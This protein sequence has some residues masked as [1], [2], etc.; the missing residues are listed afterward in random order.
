M[1]K[2]LPPQSTVAL[3]MVAPFSQT[4]LRPPEL[5]LE[6]ELLELLDEDEELLDD[7]LLDDELDEDELLEEEL[8][9]LLELLEDEDDDELPDPP[10]GTEHSLTPPA[11]RPP[12]VASLHTKLPTSVL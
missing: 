1:P 11:M 3:V 8:L 12:K 10:E 6:E 4:L 9:E 2:V 5:E 7:E